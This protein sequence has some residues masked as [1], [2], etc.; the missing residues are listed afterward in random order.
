MKGRRGERK[1][2]EKKKIRNRTRGVLSGGKDHDSAVITHLSKH[3][4]LFFFD[5]RSA[6]NGRTVA[7]VF[8]YI[9]GRHG[10]ADAD[11]SSLVVKERKDCQE[12][13]SIATP[14]NDS[15][16]ESRERERRLGALKR[17]IAGFGMH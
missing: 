12:L 13:M 11:G 6:A 1:R 7:F 4:F 16:C 3:P 2:G 8:L 17:Q 10:C 9:F 15:V 14:Q 5:V